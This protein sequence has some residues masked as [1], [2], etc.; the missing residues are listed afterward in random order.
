[1]VC[2]R[3][4]S[5]GFSE[6]FLFIF[7]DFEF[8]W[9]RFRWR[10]LGVLLL[11]LCVLFG[12]FCWCFRWVLVCCRGVFAVSWRFQHCLGVFKMFSLVFSG[13]FSKCLQSYCCGFVVS[14]RGVFV[15]VFDGLFGMFCFVFELFSC[16]NLRNTALHVQEILSFSGLWGIAINLRQYFSNKKTVHFR[17]TRNAAFCRNQI[18][19]YTPVILD[20]APIT[21]R[22]HLHFSIFFRN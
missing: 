10:V 17:I 9:L 20:Y 19:R 21:L 5:V 13:V 8:F 11:V 12:V 1:M 4:V 22:L 15:G 3:G 18:F 16:E 2:F 7:Y 14:F 6:V